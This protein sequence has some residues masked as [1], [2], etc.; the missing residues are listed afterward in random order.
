MITVFQNPNPLAL[1]QRWEKDFVIII[2]KIQT[3]I[4]LKNLDINRTED[5]YKYEKNHFRNFSTR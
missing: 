5:I 2:W 4:K 3:K 1:A